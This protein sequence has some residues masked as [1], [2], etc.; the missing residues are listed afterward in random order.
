LLSEHGREGARDAD[1]PEQVGLQFVA[2]VGQW[3]L[4][5][6]RGQLDA[7]VVDEDRDVGRRLRCRGDGGV[8]SDIEDQRNDP[9]VAWRM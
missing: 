1:D 6:G 7:G 4:E 8:V 9:C 2:D 3:R 5:Y